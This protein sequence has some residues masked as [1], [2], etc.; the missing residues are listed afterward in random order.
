MKDLI[1][2]VDAA[3]SEHHQVDL[4]L[5]PYVDALNVA[6]GGHAGDP[7]WSR[8]LAAR[9]NDQGKRVHLHPGYPDRKNFGRIDIAMP[10][11]ELAQSLTIQRDV[12]P[13]TTAC[14]F[15]GALYNRSIGDRE[16]AEQLI[17][18]CKNS[19]VEE[20]VTMDSGCLADAAR[21]ESVA[22]LSEGFAD[23]RYVLKNDRLELQPRSEPGAVLVDVLAGLGQTKLIG[24][25]FV[26]LAGGEKH[27]IQCETVCLHG[28]GENALELARAIDN[29]KR[30]S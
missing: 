4:E 13:D 25:G 11:D 24:E 19:G 8:E 30:E 21:N 17:R 23:R 26:V 16:F 7:K 29:W 12:L 22:V 5:L 10:W 9:A 28:D 20:I 6:L 14:K 18:W 15:H 3:E 2:N 27:P 1:V